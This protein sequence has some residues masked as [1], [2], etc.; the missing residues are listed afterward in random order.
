[1]PRNRFEEILRYLHVS[2]N[3]NL[4]ENDRFGKVRHFMSMLNEKWLAH[5][6]DDTDLCVDESMIPYFGK[7]GAK[8]HIH[9]KPIRFGYKIWCLANKLGYLIQ[10]EPYQGAKTGNSIPELGVGGSVVCDLIAEL[11]EAKKYNIYIDNYF[12]SLGLIDHLSKKGFGCTGTIRRN[13]IQHAPLPSE[14]E[15]KKQTR[16]HSHSLVDTTSNLMVCSWHDN[17][18]VSVASNCHSVEPQAEAKRWSAKERK[19]IQVPQPNV[20]RMYNQYM[21]GVD[22]LDQNIGVY[23]IS[24]RKRRWW[25][26]IFSWLLSASVNNAWQLNRL[27]GESST[28]DQISFIRSIVLGYLATC[29]TN[30]I[31]PKIPSGVRSILQDPVRT[32]PTGHALI[33]IENQRRCRQCHKKVQKLCV[34]CDV[35]LHMECFSSFHL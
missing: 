16:G 17:N 3:E 33:R 8:Q 5:F 30:R 35:P 32:D 11:P 19:S 22:Q 25:W 27:Y 7:H 1:M 26:P 18:V 4:P 34:K 23:R 10:C 24:I 31:L 12:T 28:S 9:G 6:P 29:K 20:L 15:M 2:D 13:R 21:G 14:K